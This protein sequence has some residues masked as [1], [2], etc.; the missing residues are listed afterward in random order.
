MFYLYSIQFK[1]TLLRKLIV[2]H[3]VIYTHDFAVKKMEQNT[4]KF[5]HNMGDIVLLWTKSPPPPSA[6]QTPCFYLAHS[7]LWLDT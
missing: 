1:K 4:D 5:E 2:T 3:T 6:S 7:H